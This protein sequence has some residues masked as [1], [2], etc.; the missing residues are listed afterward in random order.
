MSELYLHIKVYLDY[1]PRRLKYDKL[2]KST[3]L[4]FWVP[5]PKFVEFIP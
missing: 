2:G 1:F 5:V 3:R 4:K